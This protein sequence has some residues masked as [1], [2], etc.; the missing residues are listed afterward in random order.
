ML[1][2]LKL[3]ESRLEIKFSVSETEL[4]SDL[5]ILNGEEALKIKEEIN[6]RKDKKT[7]S[8]ISASETQGMF[9]E[10]RTN[11][12]LSGVPCSKQVVF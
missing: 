8:H 4:R 3:V 10:Q 11:S 6:L 5:E 7:S 1:N 12:R 2:S 9:E